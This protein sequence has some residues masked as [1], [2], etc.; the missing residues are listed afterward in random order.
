[1]DPRQVLRSLFNDTHHLVHRDTL[2][3]LRVWCLSGR[4]QLND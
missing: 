2:F 4:L 1:M 3:T